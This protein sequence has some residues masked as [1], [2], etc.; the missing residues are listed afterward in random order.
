MEPVTAKLHLAGIPFPGDYS[1][2]VTHS[3]SVNIA[4][5]AVFTTVESTPRDPRAQQT[6]MA[7]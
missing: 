6:K 4:C 1:D 5:R 3:D 2:Y 7:D